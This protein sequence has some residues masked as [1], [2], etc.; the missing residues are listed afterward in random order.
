MPRI[1]R[2]GGASQAGVTRGRRNLLLDGD[3]RILG[4]TRIA[5]GHDLAVDDDLTAGGDM[6]VAT[7]ATASVAALGDV[8]AGGAVTGDNVSATAA[9]RWEPADHGWKV[10]AY[11][12]AFVVAGTL[13]TGGT[14][15]LDR[16]NIRS[17]ITVNT[18][19]FWSSV[20]GSGLTADQN[21]I[22]IYSLAGARLITV[23]V[24][25]AMAA[26]AGLQ[27]VALGST[28]S[29]PAGSYWFAWLTNGGTAPTIARATAL[30]AGTAVLNGGL[31]AATARSATG[32]TSQTTLPTSITPASNT[33]NFAAMWFALGTA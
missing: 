28:L 27:T 19:Y 5:D 18:A 9:N 11:D 3:V 31:T 12:P 4:N 20:T 21:Y 15:K 26:T 29:L 25:V 1:T 32:P 33:T 16:F 24:D 8:S 14:V 22:G 17:D 2:L 10:W 7:V 6:T 13:L 30:T 23:D